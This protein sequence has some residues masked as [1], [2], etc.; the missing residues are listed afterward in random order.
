VLV[1]DRPITKWIEITIQS[2]DNAGNVLWS[3]KASDRWSPSGTG[4]LLNVLDKTHQIIDAKLQFQQEPASVTPRSQP[5][6]REQKMEAE[7]PLQI[8]ATP[9]VGGELVGVPV[10]ETFGTMSLTSNPDGAEINVDD[11]FAG[12]APTTLKLRPGQHAIRVFMKDYNNWS[13]WITVEAG[14]QAL[15]TATLTKS[16]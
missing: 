13:Q 5:T 11:S 10:S 8:S 1:V 12:N 4:G 16:N 2:R 6:A 7:F 14:S 3:E 15:I 9:A